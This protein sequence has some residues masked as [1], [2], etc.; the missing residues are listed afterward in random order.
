LA[1]R[2]LF[3]QLPQKC[4]NESLTIPH[5]LGL[6]AA[7]ERSHGWDEPTIF[8][9]YQQTCSA[10]HWQSPRDRNGS[11]GPFIQQHFL[12]SQ[13]FGECDHLRLS[14][15]EEGQ[16]FCWHRRDGADRIQVA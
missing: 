4:L 9:P 12:G 14:P 16:Q 5:T 8:G 15:I 6:H 13:L 10:N 11:C 1:R 3:P 2:P 7:E